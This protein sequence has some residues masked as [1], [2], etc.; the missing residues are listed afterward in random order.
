[1]AR[2]VDEVMRITSAVGVAPRLAVDDVEIDGYL[3]PAGTMVA[4]SL[5][6][7]NYDPGAFTDPHKL[8][9]TSIRAPH[10]SFGGG[11]HY[12][13]GANLARAE[14]QEALLQLTVLM[15]IFTLDGAPTWRSPMGIFGP[16]TLPLRFPGPIDPLRS[17][18]R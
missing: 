14:M 7:A 17:E 18:S 6:A 10:H 2:A 5:T 9:I 16:E 4:L 1:V 11:P 8:D 12:C 15:P 3:V 13:L